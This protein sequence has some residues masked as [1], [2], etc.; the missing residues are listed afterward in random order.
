MSAKPQLGRDSTM[1]VTAKLIA[2]LSPLQ[3]D[4]SLVGRV[5]KEFLGDEKLGD[6]RLNTQAK[7]AARKATM[8]KGQSIKR[9]IEEGILDLAPCYLSLITKLLLGNS[10]LADVNSARQLRKHSAPVVLSKPRR[11]YKKGGGRPKKAAAK[12]DTSA[13][14]VDV[15]SADD[16]NASS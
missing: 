12:P 1:V 7:K 15:N 14:A 10:G 9:T 8:R 13:P 2:L 5:A 16:A 3:L 11:T 4:E 6:T